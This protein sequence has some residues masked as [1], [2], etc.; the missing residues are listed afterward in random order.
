LHRGQRVLDRAAEHGTPSDLRM[1]VRAV[2][3]RT[4]QAVEVLQ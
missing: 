1:D 4:Q 3:H 2:G